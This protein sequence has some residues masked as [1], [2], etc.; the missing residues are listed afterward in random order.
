MKDLNWHDA[1]V[2]A[3]IGF[4]ACLAIIP[5]LTRPR[6]KPLSKPQGDER[7]WTDAYMKDVKNWRT[8]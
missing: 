4:T 3:V 2:C 7:N 8:R 5:A 6:R 1:V